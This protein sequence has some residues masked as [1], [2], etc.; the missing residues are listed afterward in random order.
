MDKRIAKLES[1]LQQLQITMK[2]MDGTLEILN[3]TLSRF[4]ESVNHINE[5]EN[6]LYKKEQRRTIICASAIILSVGSIAGI[7]TAITMF[8]G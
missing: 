5:I 1:E 8:K 2:M 6:I 7:L 3:G 4:N